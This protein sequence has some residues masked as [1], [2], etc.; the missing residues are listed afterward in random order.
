MRYVELG[1]T[2]HSLTLL[3]VP[4]TARPETEMTTPEVPARP[5]RR[6]WQ[7]VWFHV[8]LALGLALLVFAFIGQPS[9]SSMAPTLE[10]GD[11]IVVNRLAYVA[12]D[13]APGD[14]VVFRPGDGWT[15]P[16]PSS[17]PLAAGLAAIGETTGL[18][19][20]VLV[21]RVIAGPGQTVECCDAEGSVL[22]D[23]EPLSEPYVT[24]NLPFAPGAL[25]CDTVPASTRCF[26]AV[27]VPDH[28]YLM[29]GDN[30]A[31]SDDSAFPCRGDADAGEECFRWMTRDEVFG[32]VGPILWPISRWGAP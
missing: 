31:N 8:A 11:R 7:S 20:Y 22:V 28:S 6:P 15:R 26:P 30:R 16:A 32:R 10:P 9:S 12:A 27:T 23:G 3:G 24:Q 1:F 18:R 21:K 17:N 19:P 2:T 13:P 5:R 25:D 14:I 4:P 29:L